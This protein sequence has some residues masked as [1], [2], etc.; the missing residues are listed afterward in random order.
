ME[1]GDFLALALELQKKSS[2]EAALRTSIS[3][4][5]YAI[6]NQVVHYLRAGQISLPKTHEAHK[7]AFQYLAGCG[8]PEAETLADTLDELRDARNDADYQLKTLQI[9]ANECRLLCIKAGMFF[10]ELGAID[11]K[12]LIKKIQEYQKKTNNY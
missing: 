8:M 7:K 1:A 4:A 3:R 9:E 2:S 6:F 12:H 5:Y 11:Q 10:K